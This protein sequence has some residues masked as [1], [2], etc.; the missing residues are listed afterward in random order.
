MQAAWKYKTQTLFSPCAISQ[1]SIEPPE[2][3]SS[4]RK[5]F[6]TEDQV[7]KNKMSGHC[8]HKYIL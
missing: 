8:T 5:H 6:S 4:S 3:G 7:L 1:L 2:N